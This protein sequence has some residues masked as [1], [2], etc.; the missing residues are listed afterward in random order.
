MYQI[1]PSPQL[2]CKSL[3]ARIPHRG[4]IVTVTANVVEQV[5][6]TAAAGFIL[7]ITFLQVISIYSEALFRYLQCVCSRYGYEKATL[8]GI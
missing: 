5:I 3:M 8:L 4:S 7:L 6:P 1:S 2:E